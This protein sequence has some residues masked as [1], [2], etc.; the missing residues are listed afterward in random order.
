MENLNYPLQFLFK[1]STFHNDFTIKDQEQRSIAYVRQKMLKLKEDI[2]IFSDESRSDQLYRIQADRWLD[3]N[4]HY[5]F[6]DIKTGSSLGKVGRKGMRSLWKSHYNAINTEGDEDFNI[7][8][9]NG[10]VKLGDSLL[11][12]IPILN[13]F[14]GY[15]LN[16]SYTMYDLQGNAIFQMKKEPSFFGRKFSLAKLAPVD[17]KDE[18]RLILSFMMMVLLERQRG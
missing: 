12:E 13:I 16:P 6:T 17:P 2:M 14:T 10:W 5:S 18:T 9:D 7:Q 1:I 15:F 8:E 3:F 4:A 11:G